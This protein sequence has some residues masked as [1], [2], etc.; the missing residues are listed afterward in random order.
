MPEILFTLDHATVTLYPILPDSDTRELPWGL[1]DVENPI[2]LGAQADNIRMIRRLLGVPHRPTG[3]KYPVVHY[4]GEEN[5]ITFG[6]LWTVNPTIES[7]VVDPDVPDAFSPDPDGKYVLA[8]TWQEPG[9]KA[10]EDSYWR[11]R[12][13]YG[14]TCPEESLGTGDVEFRT[15]RQFVAS[16]FKEKSG[17]GAIPED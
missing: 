6:H 11:S 5:V 8:I 9:P 4:V 10:L 2:W 17:L 3:S 12:V 15:E 7:G 1:A 14:V 16:F 13:Y